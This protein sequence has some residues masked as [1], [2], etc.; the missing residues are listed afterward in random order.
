MVVPL[1]LDPGSVSI[2]LQMV[3]GGVV[4]VLVAVKMFWNRILVILHLRPRDPVPTEPVDQ[5]VDR[6]ESG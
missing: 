5:P 6:P 1:Y 4:A 2:L 3:G